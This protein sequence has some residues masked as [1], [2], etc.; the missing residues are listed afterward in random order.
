MNSNLFYQVGMSAISFVLK[1]KIYRRVAWGT[2]H[3]PVPFH[4]GNASGRT[5]KTFVATTQ[6]QRA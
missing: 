3:H 4:Q 6:T 5:E 1:W 2:D